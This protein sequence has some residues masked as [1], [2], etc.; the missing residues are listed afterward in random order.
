MLEEQAPLRQA[1]ICF[2]YVIDG[3]FNIDKYIYILEEV[4]QKRPSS[5]I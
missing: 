2:V 5:H 1:L 3:A 4:L